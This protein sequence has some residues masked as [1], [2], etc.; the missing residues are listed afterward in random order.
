MAANSNMLKFV[1][2]CENVFVA[3]TSQ[4]LNIINIVDKITGK[5]LPI[6]AGKLVVVSKI[7]GNPGRYSHVIRIIKKDKEELLVELNGEIEIIKEKPYAQY[8]GTFFNLLFKEYGQYKIE[9]LIDDIKQNL[10]A[11]LYVKQ[12]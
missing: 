7:L 12:N 8:I 9:I 4:T 5:D 3:E 2:A 6:M 10:S 11:E 1:I